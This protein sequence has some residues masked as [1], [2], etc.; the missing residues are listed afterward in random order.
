MLVLLSCFLII[1][2]L[3]CATA[4]VGKYAKCPPGAYGGRNQAVGQKSSCTIISVFNGIADPI[5]ICSD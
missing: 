2:S 4:V 3:R 5:L 1:L